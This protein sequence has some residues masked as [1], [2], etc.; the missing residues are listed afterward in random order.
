MIV[1]PVIEGY[2][3]ELQATSF[4]RLRDAGRAE[5]ERR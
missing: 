1:F 3:R 4:P 2:R 5:P